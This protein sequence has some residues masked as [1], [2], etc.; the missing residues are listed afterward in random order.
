MREPN[1]FDGLFRDRAI[2]ENSKF[3]NGVKHE[4]ETGLERVDIGI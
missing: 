2:D 4:M 1:R 3:E